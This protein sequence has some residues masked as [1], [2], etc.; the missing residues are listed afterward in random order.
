MPCMCGDACCPS[1]GPAQG[2]HKC[3]ICNEWMSEGCIH[4]NSRTGKLKKKYE[5]EAARLA[6]AE[7]DS[8]AKQ[9]EDEQKWEKE[10]EEHPIQRVVHVYCS[11]CG[12]LDESTVKALN[13][14]EGLQGEDILTFECPGC[15]TTQK[16]K[17]TA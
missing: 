11:T 9:Y 3:P 7:A 13:I 2:N 16:S 14:E 5:A 12:Q 10:L 1:C 15:L 8:L 4:I 17:R 6:Q